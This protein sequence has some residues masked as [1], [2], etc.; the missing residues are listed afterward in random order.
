MFGHTLGA[1]APPARDVKDRYVQPCDG[2]EA[3]MVWRMM[4]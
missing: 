3:V 4:R 1:T 2:G